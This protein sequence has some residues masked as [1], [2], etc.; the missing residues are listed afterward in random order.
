VKARSV[1]AGNCA[2]EANLA[3]GQSKTILVAVLVGYCALMLLQFVAGGPSLVQP[4]GV[5]VR[6][7]AIV[8]VALA[9]AALTGAR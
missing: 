8:L 9:I 7:V 3:V 5:L 2:P 4:A 6:S 1:A